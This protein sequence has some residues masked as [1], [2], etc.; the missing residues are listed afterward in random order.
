M[1]MTSNLVRGA[2]GTFTLSLL[3]A[4][5]SASGGTGD[6]PGTAPGDG[7]GT[8]ST[9]GIQ[10]FLNN[11]P[12][13][14]DVDYTE[15]EQEFWVP[16]KFA[17]TGCNANP[18][19]ERPAGCGEA[20]DAAG[21]CPAGL[22]CVNNVCAAP[23]ERINFAQAEQMALWFFHVNKSGPGITHTYVQWRGDSHL[24]D[25][26]IK[27]DASETGV[28]MSAA[29]IDQYRSIIDPDGNGEVDMSGG[30]Y[31]AGDFL[32]IG[33]TENYA[34]HTLAWTMWEF[35][36]SFSETGMLTEALGILKWH[37]DYFMKNTYIDK[38]AT[39]E[40]PWTWQVVAY[41][42]QVGGASDHDCGWMPPELRRAEKCPRKGYFATI[43]DPYANVTAGAA[44]A[45]A[46]TGW[47]FRLVDP[48]YAAQCLN[49]AIALYNLA[50]SDPTSNWSVD[51]LYVSEDGTDDLAWAALWLHEVLPDANQPGANELTALYASHK[52]EYLE[53]VIKPGGWVESFRGQGPQI[54]TIKQGGV[55]W[56]ESWTYCWNSLRSGIFVKLA[57]VLGRYGNRYMQLAEGFKYIAR[58]DS[59]SWVT[60]A[61]VTE[62][63][64]S[65]KVPDTWG[66]A[67][68]NSAAQLVALV[69]AKAFPTDTV[70]TE[71]G[72]YGAL[73]GENTAQ[74]LRGWAKFQSEYLL[75]ANP[76][77]ESYMMGFNGLGDHYAD[78]AHHAA[79]HASIYGLCDDPVESK[80][81]AYGALVS[82]PNAGDEHSDERCDFG[83]NE[84]TIDY[85]A[86]FVGALAANYY[87][88]GGGQCPD[89]TFPPME[90]PFD[91]Y[92]TEGRINTEDACKVQVEVT[93]V[94]ETAQ[95]P[96]FD[97]KLTV[98]YY[99]DAS[100]LQAKGVDPNTIQ[101]KII[102]E[103][104]ADKPT[105]LSELK[106]CTLNTSTYYFEM[107]HPYEFWG[108]Q[109]WLEGP[110]TVL[111]EVSVPGC[112][113]DFS[114]DW[115]YA[116]LTSEVQ[117]SPSLPAYSDGKIVWGAEPEC[118]EPPRVVVPPEIVY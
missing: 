114:N 101:A 27:L 113:G 38:G 53:D 71:E 36:E 86:S 39:P 55:A 9:S 19:R 82:G 107:A 3:I 50:K 45:L 68:Y 62:G 105:Q 85:N 111:L 29:Y 99:I 72:D 70:P 20:C 54:E 58:D 49:H 112:D 46:L 69:Y 22:T 48:D 2:A 79:T 67:R 96:R 17:G 64:Y 47:H 95:P 32:K 15:V 63:G 76:I 30:M 92:Y 83:A 35:P 51:G 34:A 117:K 33:I 37:A 75:G 6:G 73:A 28:N 65:K 11:P 40:D 44:A 24:D 87:F 66:T 97:D 10:D 5:C 115:A 110:R 74:I 102:Y 21:E 109:V 77:N 52:A 116:G 61:N 103:N 108:R 56:T 94:N 98:R 18:C 59:L 118:D 89:P 93:L 1:K 43:D 16:P 104:W 42:H 41:G 88:N 23:T 90:P 14:L 4:A 31:D 12:P 26:H 106:A 100:E 91:E 81:V 25:A 8:G 78:A 60:T 7:N 80:H 13:I 84:I 57:E